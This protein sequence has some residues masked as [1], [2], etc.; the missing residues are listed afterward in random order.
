MH[1]ASGAIPLGAFD[2]STMNTIA[3][4][5]MIPAQSSHIS[6]E[7]DRNV[8]AANAAN[9]ALRQIQQFAA[10]EMDAARRM[11]RGRTW[12]QL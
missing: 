1:P 9:L 12:Q 7:D 11:R 5:P 4:T 10:L 6:L 3:A 8:V 2:L